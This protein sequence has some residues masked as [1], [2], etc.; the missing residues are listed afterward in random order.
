VP[1]D[2]S[3]P[4]RDYLVVYRDAVRVASEQRH[5]SPQ[6]LYSTDCELVLPEE[7]KRF[8]RLGR[9][10]TQRRFWHSVHPRARATVARCDELGKRL[11]EKRDIG[12]LCTT[13]SYKQV[14]ARDH[15]RAI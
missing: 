15:R 11:M 13:E 10:Q 2:A 12:R 8:R 14:V 4:P 6:M 5:T 3:S 1:A 9:R 7:A